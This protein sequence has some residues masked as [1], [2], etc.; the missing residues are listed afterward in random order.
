MLNRSA[1]I[2]KALPGK[3]DIK[4]HSPSII[5][6]QKRVLNTKFTKLGLVNAYS[7]TQQASRFNKRFQSL[8]W[9]TYIKP[10]I[11]RQSPYSK[12]PGMRL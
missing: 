12:V 5:S 4:M 2:L 11:K 10:D 9:Q 8:A 7:I 3:L 6:Y 1:S